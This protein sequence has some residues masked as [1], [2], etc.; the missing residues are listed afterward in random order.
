MKS[1]IRL[2]SRKREQRKRRKSKNIKNIFPKRKDMN[3]QTEKAQYPE[4]KMKATHMKA[5]HC[6]I[7]ESESEEKILKAFRRKNKNKSQITYD[8]NRMASMVRVKQTLQN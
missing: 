4:Q 8:E 1:N 2:S 3:F 7:S 5:C 6:E